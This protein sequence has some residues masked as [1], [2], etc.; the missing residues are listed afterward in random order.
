MYTSAFFAETDPTE[1]DA[2]VS[3]HAL[4]VLISTGEMGFDA[5]H[6]PLLFEPETDRKAMIG[7]MARPNDHWRRL[8]DG[9]QVLAIFRGPDAYVTPT[10]YE[11]EP[12][13]PTWNYSA[14]H[15]HG[16]WEAVTERAALRRI[17]N[18]S[19]DTYER[20]LGTGWAM[21]DIPESL[22]TSLSR[23]VY[24]FRIHVD[25]LEA[26]QKLS[27]DKCLKD[28]QAVQSSLAACPAHGVGAA[29]Q[30]VTMDKKAYR[31]G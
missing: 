24:A 12:D 11:A 23:G 6:A 25:R 5:T 13:V 16:R 3:Q 26:A 18:L 31:P 21:S 27:Q 14:V 20:V 19:V 8:K 10:L 15:V 9:D 4:G 2:L 30:R 7:H 28:A 22:V 17:L 1:I 29:M